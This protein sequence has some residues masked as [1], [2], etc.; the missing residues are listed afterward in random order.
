ME[1][2]FCY[3]DFKSKPMAVFGEKETIYVRK[4]DHL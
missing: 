3:S 1:H 4:K 2:Y